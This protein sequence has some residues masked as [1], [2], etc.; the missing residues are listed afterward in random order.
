MG[1]FSARYQGATVV[2][3]GDDGK[4]KDS[5]KTNDKGEY[6]RRRAAG[7]TRSVRPKPIPRSAS[8]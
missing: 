5:T 2:L 1:E 3:F 8:G 4:G 6:V 7:Y